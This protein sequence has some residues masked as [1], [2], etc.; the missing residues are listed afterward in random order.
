MEG[1]V[2]KYK[3]KYKGSIVVSI[4][5][6]ALLSIQFK[7]V[8][9]QN[10]GPTTLKKGEELTRELKSLKEKESKLKQDI[11]EVKSSIDKYKNEGDNVKQNN[12]AKEISKY[13]K[14]AGYTD[15]EGEGID[16]LI[17]SIDNNVN[18]IT[19]NFEILLSIINKLNSAQAE[20][21]SINNQ[22]IVSDT[23]INLEGDEIKVN[24]VTIKE[25]F[26]IKAIGDKE[27]LE[28]TLKIKYGIV[29]E[30]ER[31][32]GATVNI[33]KRDNIKINKYNQKTEFKYSDYEG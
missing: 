11:K 10:E 6:G 25:P 16:I 8:N 12:I 1:E 28:A 17:K 23:Y 20:A 13:E 32:Y 5:L 3:K 18:S 24:E 26:E 31:Y 9:L 7:S 27:I 15:V 14:L 22:R 4:I 19:Y 2:L 21:I 30:I 29:W 33:E